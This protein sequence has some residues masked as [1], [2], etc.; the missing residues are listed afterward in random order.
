MPLPYEI[1]PGSRD[2]RTM[3]DHI[4]ARYELMNSVM[5]FGRDRAWRR[6]VIEL[7]APPANGSLLDVGTGTGSIAREAARRRNDLRI[8]GCD[9]S[10]QMLDV[11]K[12]SR[13]GDRVA[14]HLADAFALPFPD[15]TFD[16]ITSGYLIRN[17]GDPAVAF[18]E[19]ARVLKPGGRIVCLETAPVP[20]GIWSPVVRLYLRCVLPTLGRLLAGAGSAYNYL[21][22]TTEHF[23]APERMAEIITK[24]AGL[25]VETIERRMFETQAIVAATKK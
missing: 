17:T 6:R 24:E 14:W 20:A 15:A 3:F 16:C 8:A 18:R 4:A 25:K 2:V 12:N 1:R 13:R 21:G 11:A 9:F 23:I 10:P 5:T 22:T 7:A 19:Q